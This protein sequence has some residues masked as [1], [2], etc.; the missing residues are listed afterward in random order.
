MLKKLGFLSEAPDKLRW[1]VYSGKSTLYTHTQTHKNWQLFHPQSL[2][3]WDTKWV[4]WQR[5]LNPQRH[6]GLW[7][8]FKASLPCPVPW[9]ERGV[10]KN[11]GLRKPP[12]YRAAGPSDVNVRHPPS[13][14]YT[15]NLNL[16]LINKTKS[17]FTPKNSNTGSFTYEGQSIYI[18][19]QQR[20][21]G[22]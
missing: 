12:R 19:T 9:F 14:T 3:C 17:L 8:F 16:T 6:F 4:L 7:C 2:H 15:G 13:K 20:V 22:L 5:I 11:G 1:L 21:A 10:Y 18:Y